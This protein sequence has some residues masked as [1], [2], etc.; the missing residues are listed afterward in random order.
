MRYLVRFMETKLNGSW[1]G[2]REGNKELFNGYGLVLQ[3]EKIL[4]IGY[5]AMWT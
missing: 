2:G 1:V 3:D 4:E 5:T